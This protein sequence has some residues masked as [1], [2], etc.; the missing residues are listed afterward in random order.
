MLLFLY[1]SRI[2]H[3]FKLFY[4]AQKPLSLNIHLKN[5]NQLSFEM[6]INNAEAIL[7]D[8]LTVDLQLN[9]AHNYVHDA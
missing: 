8:D 6:F 4:K 3:L 1:L 2:C 5:S 9:L 7:G